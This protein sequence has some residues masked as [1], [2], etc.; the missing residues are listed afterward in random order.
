MVH[1]PNE[2]WLGV[3]NYLKLPT[4]VCSCKNEALSK[5]EKV[6]QQ[7]L[8]S[9]CLVSKQFRAI[10]QPQLY[11]NFIKNKSSTAQER[12]LSPE[13]EWQHKYYQQD[14]RS[15]R[16][17]RKQTKLES[18]LITIIHRADLAAMVEHLRIGSYPDDVT[19]P[20]YLQKLYE[21]VPL[22]KATSYVCKT[23]RTAA[24]IPTW[25]PTVVLIC[26]STAYVWQSGRDAQFSAD[27]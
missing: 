25:S 1:F 18:F 17:I 4:D 14:E 13:S 20:R 3:A 10:F 15:F 12:L 23:K 19:L 7:T 26:R 16:A 9:L 24:G 21:E 6:T 27:C 8:I 5:D 11:Y 2:I 22:H